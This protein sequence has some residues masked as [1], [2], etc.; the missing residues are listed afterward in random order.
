MSNLSVQEARTMTDSAGSGTVSIIMAG[1]EEPAEGQS[2]WCRQALR[3]ALSVGARVVTNEQEKRAVGRLRYE[4]FIAR[5][6]GAFHFADHG[7]GL[8]LE[9]V[10]ALSVNFFVPHDD[11]I[12]AAVRL[13]P[14]LDAISDGQLLEVV[15]RSGLS[16]TDLSIALVI[17]RLVVRNETRAR[18][19]LPGLFRDVYRVGRASGARYCIMAC[20]PWLVALYR[21]LGFTPNGQSFVRAAAG[22]RHVAIFDA[23][24]RDRLSSLNLRIRD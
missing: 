1:L 18:L 5:D 8:F 3:E 16:T 20:S 2:E 15:C 24:D 13:T 19:R 9:P 7:T 10:D 14:A 17:S 4:H 11:A 21:R 6:K 23:L 22:E 12:L